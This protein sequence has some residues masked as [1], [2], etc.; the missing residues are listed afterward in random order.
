MIPLKRRYLPLTGLRLQRHLRPSRLACTNKGF[1]RSYETMG[2]LGPLVPHNFSPIFVI[3]LFFCASVLIYAVK[4]QE[5]G[6]LDIPVC[7]LC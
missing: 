5:P 1:S 6:M 2:E 4:I 3:I 7:L